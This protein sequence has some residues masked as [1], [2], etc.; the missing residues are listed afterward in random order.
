MLLRSIID[1]LQQSAAKTGLW[2]FFFSQATDLRL[3]A[4]TA[5]LRGLI[6][7]LLDQEPSLMSHIRK[8]YDCAGKALS[9]DA[10]A[11]FAL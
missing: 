1:D 7:L 11:W 9:E 3:N 2:A 8:E 5:I 4:S 6:Y 10:N